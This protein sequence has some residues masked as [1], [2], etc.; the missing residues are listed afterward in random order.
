M[1]TLV[2]SVTATTQHISMMRSIQLDSGPTSM[3]T[4]RVP[5]T[6]VLIS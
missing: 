4:S 5:K 6:L 3:I 2:V 1:P